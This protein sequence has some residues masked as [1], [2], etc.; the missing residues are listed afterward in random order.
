M[1]RYMYRVGFTLY[2]KL[3]R[4]KIN[5]IPSIDFQNYFSATNVGLSC[6]TLFNGWSIIS[7]KVFMVVK[8]GFGACIYGEK[9]YISKRK[10]ISQSLGTNITIHHCHRRRRH[11]C[12]AVGNGQYERRCTSSYKELKVNWY[13][14]LAKEN[15]QN[16]L[17]S[18]LEVWFWRSNMVG[19]WSYYCCSRN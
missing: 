9:K 13:N 14:R 18:V 17:I 5:M 16:D 1:I 8:F 4:S 3:M 10:I 12:G 19:R 6:L 2:F 11:G 7:L 15:K